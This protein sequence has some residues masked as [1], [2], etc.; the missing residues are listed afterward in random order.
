[1]P[2]APARKHAIKVQAAAF[3]EKPPLMSDDLED[4]SMLYKEE[5]S[6]NHVSHAFLRMDGLTMTPKLRLREDERNALLSWIL[7]YLHVSFG[8]WRIKRSTQMIRAPNMQAAIF[9]SRSREHELGPRTD[10][11]Q[12]GHDPSSRVVIEPHL[13]IFGVQR[14]KA[15]VRCKDSEKRYQAMGEVWCTGA[16]S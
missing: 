6:C 5:K 12:S 8:I 2:A 7:K 13:A 10:A 14:G 3:G 11:A 9:V 16:T 15:E 4:G 1:M